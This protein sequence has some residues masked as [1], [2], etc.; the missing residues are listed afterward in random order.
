[1]KSAVVG[2]A[3]AAK[4]PIGAA[5][6]HKLPGREFIH[7]IYSFYGTSLAC[8]ILKL[9]C[10]AH[11]IYYTSSILNISRK[12]SSQLLNIENVHCNNSF[13]NDKT[14]VSSLFSV[15]KI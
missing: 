6:P 8:N 10:P 1:V 14:L 13:K 12:K 15:F 5:H 11:L 4:Q 3:P 9:L 7:P 2:P